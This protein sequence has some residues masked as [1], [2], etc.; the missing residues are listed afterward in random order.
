MFG[1]RTAWHGPGDVSPVGHAVN[2]HLDLVS[3]NFGIHEF[4]G[5][6]DTIRQVFPGAPEQR[7]GYLYVNDKPGHGVDI[8]LNL[9][10]KFP[11]KF[12]LDTWTQARLPDGS[13]GRP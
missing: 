5:F 11:C 12:K 10:A 2:V 6:D 13:M 1:V 7:G 4:C 9:A 8:D 3:P